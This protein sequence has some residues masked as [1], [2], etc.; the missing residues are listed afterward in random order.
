LSLGQKRFAFSGLTE[1]S[2]PLEYKSSG[3]RWGCVEVWCIWHILCCYY[4]AV[5]YT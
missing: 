1:A 2:S 5:R 3:K 4:V